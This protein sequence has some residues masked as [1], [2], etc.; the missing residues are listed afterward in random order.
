MEN[1]SSQKI[2]KLK[3]Q[4]ENEKDRYKM[5]IENLQKKLRDLKLHRPQTEN[6]QTE[7]ERKFVSDENCK[8]SQV[9]VQFRTV[10]LLK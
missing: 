7:S 10:V 5:D 1:E 3:E 8:V 6:G 9:L 2:H 4:L